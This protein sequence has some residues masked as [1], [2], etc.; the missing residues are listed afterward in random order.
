[1]N[2]TDKKIGLALSGGGVRAMAFHAG[3]LKYLA[4]NKL[5][6]QVTNISSV[7]GGSLFTGLVFHSAGNKWPGDTEYINIVM[8][9]IKKLMT[10]ASL[11]KSSMLDLLKPSNWKNILNRGEVIAQTIESLWGV[12]SVLSDLPETPVWTING[13]TG[14]NGRRFRFKKGTM[15]DYKTGYAE[16]KDFKTAKAMAVSAAFP[17]GIGPIEIETGKYS[18]EKQTGWNT[19]IVEKVVPPY[20]KMHIYDG[21]LYD[22]LGS[23]SFYDV[24]EQKVKSSAKN[25]DFIIISDAGT[26]FDDKP[27]PDPLSFGRAGNLVNILMDQDRSLRVRSFQNFLKTHENAGI[28]MSLGDNV[29]DMTKEE[30]KVAQ[31]Y[32]TTLEK[33]TEKDFDILA[34]YG[35]QAA[36]LN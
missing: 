1:M 23:E 31:N 4:E 36:S 14:E 29:R 33:M 13:T 5:L 17:I 35:H 18:W 6:A 27:L 19:G 7:S 3:L 26:P 8:P 2:F 11:Q 22:N 25:L 12:K 32:P 16:A 24:G 30:I 34:K 20:K 15:G 21:G 10:T 9:K 28:Y